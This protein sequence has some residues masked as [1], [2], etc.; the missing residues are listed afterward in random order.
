ML[1]DVVQQMLWQCANNEASA[2]ECHDE[3]LAENRRYHDE[4]MAKEKHR[5]DSLLEENKLEWK[6]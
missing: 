4:P 5:Y 1:N 6:A 3:I 2:S